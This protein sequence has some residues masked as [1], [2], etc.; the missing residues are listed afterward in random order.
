MRI[1]S[2]SCLVSSA[3]AAKQAIVGWS[4]PAEDEGA[5]YREAGAHKVSV[6]KHH[7]H[8]HHHH[9]HNLVDVQRK[10]KRQDPPAEEA[11]AAP[12]E[13]APAEEAPAGEGGGEE[14]APEEGEVEVGDDGTVEAEVEDA[15]APMSAETAP[16]EDSNVNIQDDGSS[17]LLPA[18]RHLACK[19]QCTNPICEETCEPVC[20]A[21]I[22]KTFCDKVIANSCETSCEKPACKVVC[23]NTQDASTCQALCEPAACETKCQRTCESHCGVPQCVLECKKPKS[24]PNPTCNL[25]CDTNTDNQIHMDAGRHVYGSKDQVEMAT[26]MASLGGFCPPGCSKEQEANFLQSGKHTLQRGSC[27]EGCWQSQDLV[28]MIQI[29]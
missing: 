12:A 5:L 19:W 13:E 7:H 2:A 17:A 20:A 25:V 18:D 10:L 27:P 23:P 4:I 6:R 16:Q 11:A 29:N 3:F 28:Q 14:P 22:C 9:K 1:F 8:H 24:C 26:G 21:P 15:A